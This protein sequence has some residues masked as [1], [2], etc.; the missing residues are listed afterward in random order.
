MFP[1]A[2]LATVNSLTADAVLVNIICWLP[3]SSS[4]PVAVSNAIL[5]PLVSKE[6]P[7][8]NVAVLSVGDVKV[9]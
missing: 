2:A 7:N 4:I 8:D 1:V 5:N 6:A 3:E 9:Y